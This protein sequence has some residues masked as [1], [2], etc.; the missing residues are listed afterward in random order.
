MKQIQV[1]TLLPEIFEPVF[2]SSMLWKAQKNQII[3]F[4]IINLRDFGLGPRKQVDDTPYGGGDGMLLMIEP[5]TRAVRQAKENDPN[6][7]VILTSPRGQTLD[8]PLAESLAS[9]ERGLILICGRYEGV[10]E[11]IMSLVDQTISLGDFVLTGGEIPAMAIVDAVTRLLPGVL[12]GEQSAQIESFADGTKILEFPQYTR[13]EE[14]EGQRVPEVLLSGN[15]AKI[16]AWRQD[17][18]IDKNLLQ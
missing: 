17:H 13:P 6:A 3:K 14:F 18:S 15:H 9:D 16:E 1:I 7:L 4:E 10:D 12:G 8:Q 2:N 11:R 5:L